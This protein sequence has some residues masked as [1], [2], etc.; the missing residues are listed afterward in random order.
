MYAGHHTK[1]ICRERAV[2]TDESRVHHQSPSEATSTILNS[3]QNSLTATNKQSLLTSDD[4][5]AS[6]TGMTSEI[7]LMPLSAAPLY[8]ATVAAVSRSLRQDESIEQELINKLA[9]ETLEEAR[10]QLLLSIRNLITACNKK[11]NLVVCNPNISRIINLLEDDSSSSAIKAQIALLLCSISKSGED[12]IRLLNEHMVDDRLLKL[13]VNSRDEH[14]VEA[15][16]RCMRSLMSWPRV[17]RT[18]LLYES[19]NQ[20]T[21]KGPEVDQ[22][23]NL[24]MIISYAQRSSSIVIQE[25]VADVFAATCTRNKDQVLLY[26][27]S[28]LPC[29][30]TLLES[31]SDRVVIAALNWLTQICLRNHLISLE[32]VNTKCLSGI[33]ILDRL[34]HLMNKDLC[35]ELQFLAA[36]AFAHIYRALT[37]NDLK[38]DARI[39]SYVLPTLVR[40][41]QPDKPPH[42]RVKSAECIAYLI[43][44]E[45]SLQNIASICDHL[46]DSLANMLDCEGFPLLTDSKNVSP[47]RLKCPHERRVRWLHLTSDQPPTLDIRPSKLEQ[48]R[49]DHPK[50]LNQE[51]NQEMKRAAFLALASLASNLEPIR[52]KIFNTKPVKEHLVGSLEDKDTKT[53]KSVLTCLL[54]LSRSVQQ[55]RTSFADSKVY[56]ALKGLLNTKSNDVLILVLAILCNISLDF[57]PGKHQFLDT[58]TIDLLCNLTKKSDSILRLHGMWILMNMVYQLTEQNIKFQILE[59]LDIKHVLGLLDTEGD[60]EIVLKTLGFLRN[61]LSHKLH[62]DAIMRDHG[63]EIMQSLMRILDRQCPTRIKEQS[64]CVLTNIADG[65]TSKSFIMDNRAVLSYL[66]WI[67]S[68]DQASD[69]VLAA[70][71]CIT[72][73]AHKEY[74]GS[75]E[76]RETLKKFGIE[77]KLKSLLSASDPILSDRVRTAYN[78]FL[79]GME[80]KYVN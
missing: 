29:I 38:Q 39:I 6:T 46:I 78:Q 79:V 44:C 74:D 57:S 5:S 8:S 17:S 45:T 80:D 18:W 50:D 70:V 33:S 15:C 32:I 69:L 30:I 47:T 3:P 31:K 35:Y 27:A 34:T 66:S 36:K 43:E 52:K 26:R 48:S 75:C 12:S 72:N 14:L 24:Q 40:M 28:C 11:K 49:H 59:S 16:L 55:L 25:C 4:M 13:I 23:K 71:C 10:M 60:E 76:R 63:E 56:D 61:L 67:I 58:P 19:F 7:T 9:D 68:H 21:N 53:L 37:T 77:A 64:L 73:L 65:N 20:D 2:P 62:I 22:S 42:L 1:R 41:V 54:S 51:L